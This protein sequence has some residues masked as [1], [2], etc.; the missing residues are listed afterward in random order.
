MSTNLEKIRYPHNNPAGTADYSNGPVLKRAI[1]RR[2]VTAIVDPS[3]VNRTAR[4]QLFGIKNKDISGN[5]VVYN[6]AD[7]GISS[8]RTTFMSA[9]FGNRTGRK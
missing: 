9:F 7:G 3:G 1:Q 8:T 4:A 5:N 6:V 2:T